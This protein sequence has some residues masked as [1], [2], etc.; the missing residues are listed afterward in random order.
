MKVAHII[1]RLVVGGAQENTIATVLGLR[2]KPDVDVRLISGPTYGPEGS[3]ENRVNQLPGLLTV[4]PH[5][6]RPV[7]PLHDLE[8]YNDLVRLL[9]EMRPDIVHTHSGK[10]GIIGRYAARRAGVPVIIHHIHGPSFGPFQGDLANAIFTTAEQRAGRFTRHFFCSANAMT[11]RYLAA[12]IG[13]PEQYT[14]ILSGFPLEPFLRVGDQ[15]ELRTKLGFKPDH[16]VIGKISRLA[17]LKGHADLIEAAKLIL[18]KLP[19]ARFLL[20]GDGTARGEIEQRVRSAGLQNVFVFT[21]LVPPGD[22]PALVGCMDCVAHLSSR[23]ALA[24][25][26]PQAFAAAR[27]VVTY[28]FDGANEVCLDGRTGF[29][30]P[31]GN[32][33]AA[34]ERLLQLAADADLRRRLGGAGREQVRDAFTVERMVEDQYQIYLRLMREVVSKPDGSR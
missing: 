17:P 23:E 32:I 4:T 24:R 2:A 27:P 14:R 25:A 5:L 21:G 13:S 34:A 3:L 6:I 29:L 22:I 15:T 33:A 9:G 16:F 1:T 20:V 8:A 7:H 30:V 26:L 18:P 12:G 11:Q 31:H 10:A 28:D 19:T